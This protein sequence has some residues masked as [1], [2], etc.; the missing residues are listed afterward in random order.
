MC[1][2]AHWVNEARLWDST[3][4]HQKKKKNP[5]EEELASVSDKNQNML[6]EETDNFEKYYLRN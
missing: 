2:L 1:L 4:A 5:G 6:Q 3:V